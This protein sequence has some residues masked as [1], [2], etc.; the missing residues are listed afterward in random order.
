MNIAVFGLGYVGSVTAACLASLGHDVIGVDVNEQK[1][2]TLASGRSPI[3]ERDLDAM[4]E[5]QSAAGRLSASMDAAA[6]VAA[7][8]VSMIC[9]GTPSSAVGSLD[10]TAVERVCEQIGAAIGRGSRYH[11]VVVR[12][13]V[14][15]GTI[16]D[17]VVPVLEAASG[18]SAGP[19]FGVVA[20]PEFL[21]EGSAVS[22]F[23][24]PALTVIGE[25]DPRSGATV[26]GVYEGLDSPVR[27][28][29]LETAELAKYANNAFHAVKVAFA[30]EIGTFSKAHGV[31][32]RDV[33]ALL[34]EDDR[35]NISDA[36]LSPGFAFGGSCL[37]KD[38]RALAYRAKERDLDAPLLQA[39]LPSN[40]AQIR[41]GIAMV[42]RLG[43]R[44]VAV[45]G[46]AFKAGTDDVRESPMV[47]MVETLVGRGYE[48]VV[49]DDAVVPSALVGANKSY[50]EEA[51]PHV[52]ARVTSDLEDAIEGAEIL[53]VAN[54][55]PRV[56]AAL[57]AHGREKAVVD[58]VG[59]RVTEEDRYD[60]ICW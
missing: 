9:V 8:D 29:P 11:V 49:F 16:R 21:R 58:L 24:D 28:V 19:D 56:I 7:S 48:V 53:V 59:I 25:L 10:L 39:I 54:R 30:N 52:A 32:G 50:L 42:E 14:L 47:P 43:R 35:L 60:G 20:N 18:L 6:A 27:R 12:S 40:E 38:T 13:T 55:D 26:A 5:E 51:F 22:D 17:L 44:P 4:V 36:Y 45:L 2:A 34:C 57:E 37:P 33:M 15:P 3:L 1:V 23:F 41:R 46:L 31:D